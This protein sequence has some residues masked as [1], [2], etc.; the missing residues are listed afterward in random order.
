MLNYQKGRAGY[1]SY[2][3][4][5]IAVDD[6]FVRIP[7]IIQ[8]GGHIGLKQESIKELEDVKASLLSLHNERKSRVDSFKVWICDRSVSKCKTPRHTSQKY[9]MNMGRRLLESHPFDIP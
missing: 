4:G 8:S 1:P 9:S 5:I 7:E 3:K 6:S 2:K